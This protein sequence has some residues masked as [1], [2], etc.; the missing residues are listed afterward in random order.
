MDIDEFWQLI[1]SAREVSG[2][3][4][5]F[6]EAL[7][8]LLAAR[9]EAEILAYEAHFDRLHAAV[10][11]WDLW[12]AAYLVGGGCSDD[13]FM[14][15]RAGLIAQG[16]TWYERAAADPDAL[17][18][19]PA[20]AGDGAQAEELFFYEDVNYAA[21]YAYQRRTGDRGRF[22]AEYRAH[23]ERHGLQVRES[24][25]DLG[26]DFDFDD[27]D[28]MHRRLPRLAAV[29]LTDDDPDEDDPD[30]DDV[31]DDASADDED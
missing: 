8:E 14:D 23:L 27:E 1:D 3:Q 6:D 17:A 7:V 12:A 26:E 20:M 5:P 28:E 15:F 2:P 25:E 22:E 30:G 4:R 18:D 31:D 10:Y 29:F 11:R 13:S 24:D 9:P 19:H 21:S 16:R